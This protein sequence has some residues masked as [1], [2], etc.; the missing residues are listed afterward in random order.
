MTEPV[1]F[2]IMAF[3]TVFSLGV[4]PMAAYFYDSFFGERNDDDLF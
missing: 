4:I 1:M 2:V 3:V